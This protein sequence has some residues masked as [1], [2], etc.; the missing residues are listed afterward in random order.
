MRLTKYQKEAFIRAVMQDVPNVVGPLLEEEVQ[1]ALIKGMSPPV[2]RL[3]KTNPNAL[4]VQYSY[5]FSERGNRKYF[6]GDADYDAI[7]APFLERVRSRSEAKRS[8]TSTFEGCSTL[9]QL[10]ATLPEFQKYM[11]TEEK[12]TPNLPAVANVVM[13]LVA[14]GWQP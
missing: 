2:R 3:Y 12:P 11:P 14:L 5:D 8:L 4:R 13:T 9:K 10:Q 6:V 7:T 1:N